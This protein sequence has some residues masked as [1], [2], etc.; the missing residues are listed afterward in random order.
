MDMKIFF[1]QNQI[2]TLKHSRLWKECVVIDSNLMMSL[3]LSIQK[4]FQNILRKV[5]MVRRNID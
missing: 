3:S 5:K 4:D 1:I 2:Q